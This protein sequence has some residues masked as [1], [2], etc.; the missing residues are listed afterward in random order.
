MEG[1]RACA[2]AERVLTSFSASP[3]HFEVSELALMLKNVALI[4]AAIALPISVLPVSGGPNSRIPLGAALMP[5]SAKQQ[6]SFKQT[7]FLRAT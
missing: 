1:W 3:S 4:F 7:R 6:C 5:C 2:T